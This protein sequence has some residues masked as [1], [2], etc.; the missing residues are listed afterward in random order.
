MGMR[1]PQDPPGYGAWSEQAHRAPDTNGR[2]AK[3]PLAQAV[4]NLVSGSDATVSVDPNAQIPP[5]LRAPA[6]APPMVGPTVP[7]GTNLEEGTPAPRIPPQDANNPLIPGGQIPGMGGMQTTTATTVKKGVDLDPEM[8]ARIRG[9]MDAYDASLAASEIELKQLAQTMDSNTV[10]G[11]EMQKFWEPKLQEMFE[12]DSNPAETLGRIRKA[13]DRYNKL[14]QEGQG[15]IDPTR[16]W[17]DK[18][19]GDRILGGVALFLGGLGAGPGGQ[20]RALQTINQA[21]ARDIKAQQYNIEQARREAAD[22]GVALQ[23]EMDI[24]RWVT[25]K[26][27]ET[28]AKY[29]A[30]TDA[31]LKE[32]ETRKKPIDQKNRLAELRS[33]IAKQRADIEMG[34]AQLSNDQITQSR[35]ERPISPKGGLSQKERME[36]RTPWGHAYD[37]DS[38]KI[39]R[40][41]STAYENSDAAL[42]RLENFLKTIGDSPMTLKQKGEAEELAKQWIKMNI[43]VLNSGTLGESEYARYLESSPVSPDFV[44]TLYTGAQGLGVVNAARRSNQDAAVSTAVSNMP[45]EWVKFPS[46]LKNLKNMYMQKIGGPR[47]RE[48]K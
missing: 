37:K 33:Q 6:E 8:L 17:N 29:N 2:F 23:T 32:Y 42:G 24:D 38:A 36:I 34:L 19:T 13:Q 31:R 14:I 47:V 7:P 46:R 18:T 39:V 43:A 48:Y 41:A 28:L 26:N 15:R 1:I 3:S 21:I 22:A 35:Q 30:W 11:Q 4:S 20:N 5:Q 45:R 9:D 25:R 16:F 27:M 40:A 12:Q 10:W 44:R